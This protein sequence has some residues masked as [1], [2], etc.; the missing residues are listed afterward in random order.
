M[1][2]SEVVN[3]IVDYIN[4]HKRELSIG[5]FYCV[6]ERIVCVDGTSLSVQASESHYCSP[7]VTGSPYYTQVEIGFPSNEDA[8]EAFDFGG[9]DVAGYVPI[10]DV[11]RYIIAHGGIAELEAKRIRLFR[12]SLIINLR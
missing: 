9:E 8:K 1:K 12:N 4:S 3:A 10:E 6:A 5:G 7:R 2:V 11:A